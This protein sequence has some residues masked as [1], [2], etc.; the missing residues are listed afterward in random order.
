MFLVWLKIQG[1][2]K[3]IHLTGTEDPHGNCVNLT[4]VVRSLKIVIK[5]MDFI[6]GRGIGRKA[7]GSARIL[8]MRRCISTCMDPH[9]HGKLAHSPAVPWN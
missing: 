1:D 3:W 8:L 4:Y 6:L 2:R 7:E 5:E 9:I